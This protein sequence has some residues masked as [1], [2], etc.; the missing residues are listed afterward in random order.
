MGNRTT[1]YLMGEPRKTNSHSP[2]EILPELYTAKPFKGQLDSAAQQG[3][4]YVRGPFAAQV[5]H[6]SSDFS[7]FASNS[8]SFARR[9]R[10]NYAPRSGLRLVAAIRP[11]RE[12]PVASG[13]TRLPRVSLAQSSIPKEGL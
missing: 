2:L 10:V 3:F 13:V 8:G 7:G 1:K 11:R 9:N 4:P 12:A 6:H 5:F